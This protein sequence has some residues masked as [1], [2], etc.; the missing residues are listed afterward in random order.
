MSI[1]IAGRK[2]W[3]VIIIISIIF[4]NAC[5]PSRVI[6]FNN[7]MKSGMLVC[8]SKKIELLIKKG[9]SGSDMLMVNGVSQQDTFEIKRFFIN[10]NDL[11][12][13]V[14]K[15][16]GSNIFYVKGVRFNKSDTLKVLFLF[17]NC[18]FERNYLLGNTKNLR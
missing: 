10:E 5:D 17:N 14:Q 4:L 18:E 2:F 12:G 6:L 13:E 16:D 8:G 9:M 1:I 7:S 3:T 15:E 11:S